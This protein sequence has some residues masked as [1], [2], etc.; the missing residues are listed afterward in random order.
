MPPKAITRFTGRYFFL[1]NFYVPE[2]GRS[3]EHRF[4][5][6]KARTMRDYRYV[7]AATTPAQAKRRGRQIRPR[8]DWDEIKDG[9]MEVL[10][11]DKFRKSPILRRRLL[12]TGDAHLEE[13]NDWGDD[14]WGTVDGEGENKL[15]EILMRVRD[16]IRA[17]DS[18]EWGT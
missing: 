14:Y 4:Q 11:T 8:E 6:A 12:A 7:F 1:S 10:V 5:C 2:N 15:G 13:G 3:V 17:E 18:R 9:L 16:E